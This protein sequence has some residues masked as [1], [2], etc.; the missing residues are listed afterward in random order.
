MINIK[1]KYVLDYCDINK[2]IRL[3][4][5]YVEKYEKVDKQGR[6]FSI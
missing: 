1:S 4:E 2:I 3:K 6:F 5:R